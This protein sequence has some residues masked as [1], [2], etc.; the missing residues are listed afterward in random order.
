M[1]KSSRFVA[2]D[3]ISP[4]LIIFSVRVIFWNTMDYVADTNRKPNEIV[5]KYAVETYP[6]S[7]ITYKLSTQLF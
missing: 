3:N 6:K 1:K 5:K 4:V 2:E 7:N